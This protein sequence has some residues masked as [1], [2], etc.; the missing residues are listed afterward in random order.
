[1]LLTTEKNLKISIVAVGFSA[2][3]TQIIL[4][5]EFLNIF[6][7][8]ELVIG[9]LLCNWMLITALGAFLG[10]GA[11][12]NKKPLI[13]IIFF[14]ILLALL[15]F[16]TVFAI[17]YFKDL[18]YPP[19]ALPG[20]FDVLWGSFLLM[21]PYC[22]CSGFLFTLFSKEVSRLSGRSM[23]FRVYSIEAVG[24]VAGGLVFTFIFLVFF[25]TFQ[26]LLCLA[27]VNLSAAL[28]VQ[29]SIRGKSFRPYLISAI[30]FIL[31][32][33]N[34]VFDFD[35]ISKSYIYKN[36]EILY[37][38]DTPYG[39][40]LVTK[41]AG[42]V[43]FFENGIHFFSTKNIVVNEESVHYAMIQK[44][45]AANVLLVSGG[46]SGKTDEIL[47]YS[48]KNIDYVEVNPAVIETGKRFA[49][50][51]ENEKIKV[52]NEDP[53]AFI[54]KTN[55]LYD[56]VL[57]NIPPPATA[58]LNRFYTVEFFERLKKKMSPGGIVCTSLESGGGN[59]MNESSRRL[60]GTIFNVLKNV[61]NN[62]LIIPGGKN[63]F[64]ASDS[65]LKINIAELI[66]K[67]GIQNEYVNFYYLDDGLIKNRSK[68]ITDNIEDITS[69]N[70][71]FAPAAYFEQISYWLSWFGADARIIITI[72]VALFFLL[73]IFMKKVNIGIFAAG[74]TAS[75]LEIII[76]IA[77]QIIFGY[78]YQAIALLISAFMAGLAIGAASF[79]KISVKSYFRIF[80]IN[81]VLI[82]IMAIIFPLLLKVLNS[83]E[84]SGML[85]KIVFYLMMVFSGVL[86]GL[87]FSLSTFLQKQKTSVVAAR[88][89]SADLIGSAAGALLSAVILLPVAGLVGT[90][91]ILGAFNFLIVVV[92]IFSKKIIY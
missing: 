43:N 87:Q 21:L 23:I 9:C 53:R 57:L 72:I 73:L 34:L 17:Y 26:G 84:I 70:R 48:V 38:H 45:D 89:Y 69:L 55:S 18:I 20:F 30:L 62:V 32:I 82:G 44:P 7:G 50:W 56:V 49:G 59:Y 54:K 25:T 33:L 67:E 83:E 37:M 68:I 14:Q 16:F 71:D 28:L 61:F 63:Y 41:A 3:I 60:H 66:E 6:Q 58:Q 22:L 80:K 47:K 11:G 75:T 1:M 4:L 51:K 92:L 79:V 27:V 85:V 35:K 36:Q 8:N 86:T 5:R 76:L 12:A 88:A 42:Q 15:P 2:L 40:L 29:I 78:V 19:G 24:S 81:Q 13:K 52:I 10:K 91:I 46:V 65:V 90:G 31:I 74:F 39:N 77:F 64:L